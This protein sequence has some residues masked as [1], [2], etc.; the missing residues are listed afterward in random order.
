M[1]FIYDRN[2]QSM[3]LAMG[4]GVNLWGQPFWKMDALYD[5]FN[6]KTE[7]CSLAYDVGHI[8]NWRWMLWQGLQQYLIYYIAVGISD[9]INFI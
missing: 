2:V 4:S 6:Q 1:S 9:I 3:L 5:V 7:L 8:Q